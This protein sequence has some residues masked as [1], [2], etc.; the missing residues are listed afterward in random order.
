MRKTE[1]L[2]KSAK[3]RI[4]SGTG[5]KNCPAPGLFRGTP[6]LLSEIFSTKLSIKCLLSSKYPSND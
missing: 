6:S 3:E 5:P 4:Q 2:G 1:K